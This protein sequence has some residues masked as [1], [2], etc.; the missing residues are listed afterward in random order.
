MYSSFKSDWKVKVVPSGVGETVQK[1][2]TQS[3]DGRLW[4][5]EKQNCACFLSI[6]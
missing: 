6:F 4:G 1:N 3:G 2:T 5:K